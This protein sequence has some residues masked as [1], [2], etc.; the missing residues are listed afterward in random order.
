MLILACL[1]F[2]ENATTGTGERPAGTSV[3]V[4]SLVVCRKKGHV[5]THA[6]VYRT[7]ET[8]TCKRCRSIVVKPLD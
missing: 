8:Y 4:D 6:I 1:V 7:K 5:Q 2:T 3:Q